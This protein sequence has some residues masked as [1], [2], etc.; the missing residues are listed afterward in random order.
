MNP[1]DH[2]KHHDI[3]ISSLSALRD[4]MIEIKAYA[5]GRGLK[6]FWRGQMD[7]T[8]GLKSSL[9]R[10]LTNVT[11]PDD[12]LLNSVE[13]D[14]LNEGAQWIT[15]LQKAPFKEPLARLAYLQHHGI[16]TRLIDF[17][18]NPWMALFFAVE[19]MDLVD[20]RL[21]VIFV[22]DSAVMTKTP[23]G[24]P[25]RTYKTSEVRIWD[26]VLSGVSFPRLAAQEGVLAVGRLPSTQPHRMGWDETLKIDRSLLAEEVRATMSIPFKLCPGDPIPAAASPPIGLTMRIHIN[27]ESIRRDLQKNGS[28]RRV[29][30]LPTKIEHRLVYPDADGMRHHSRRLKGLAKGIII[31]I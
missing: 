8:W 28:G 24:T 26:P 16:P 29:C 27:K 4:K 9:V 1:I 12:K 17:T 7:H 2:Y 20:G 30:P 18:R 10:Q 25:W 19:G 11:I 3:M 15:D 22:S 13:D 5:D 23:T 14:I 6:V 31:P 21:F